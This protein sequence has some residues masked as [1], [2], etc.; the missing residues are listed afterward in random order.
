M[1]PVEV[2]AAAKARHKL[3]RETALMV[4]S[5]ADG[6]PADASGLAVGDVLVAAN[7]APLTDP[8]TLLDALTQVAVDGPLQLEYLRAGNKQTIAVTPVD[9]D[10][11]G[12]R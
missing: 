7:G 11:G 4:M 6:S 5:V 8:T 3:E 10:A 1:H 9:R 2:G 12:A